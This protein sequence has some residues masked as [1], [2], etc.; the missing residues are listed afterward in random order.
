MRR[1][2]SAIL[3]LLALSLIPASL[4]AR[5]TV[6]HDLKV[7]LY[8]QENRFA[9]K[10]TITVPQK[11]LPD[12]QFRLH[13][14][15]KPLS[16]TAGIRIVQQGSRP[17]TDSLASFRVTLPSGKNTFTLEYGGIINHPLEA[18]GKE[19]ARGFKQTP[20]MISEKGVY[21]A[22]SS[23]WYPVFDEELLT[24][25][26]QV[27]LPAGW[28]AVSQ[29]ERT[30][31]FKQGNVTSVRWESARPQEEIY[32]VAARFTEYVQPAGRIKA[33]VFLRTPDEELALR[34][35]DATARYVVMYEQLIGP[36]PYRKF[37]LVENF[38][39]TGFG[40]PSF[41]LLGPKVI[42]FPFILHSSYPHEI[43][44]NWWGN[45]VFPDYTRGNW[46]EGLTAYLS[47]HLIK[48]QRGQATEYRQAALQKYADYVLSGRDF[49]LVQF[50]SRHSSSSEAVGYGKSLMFFHMLRSQLGDKGFGKALQ[51]FYSKNKFQ[52]ASFEDLRRSFESVAGEDLRKEFSQWLKQPG[53]PELRISSASVRVKGNGFI[54][55]TILEQVQPGSAYYLRIPIAVTMKG[56]DR[57]YQA[58]AIM[59]QKRLE[60]EVPLPARPL[61]LDVDPE[62]DL[63]RRLDRDEIPPALTQAFGAKKMLILLP[64]AAGDALIRAYR[65]LAQSIGRSG[66]DDVTIKLDSEVQ[67]L[68]LDQAVTILGWKNL[69]RGEIFSALSGYDVT[70]NQ[71]NVTIG[72]TSIPR[73]N[74][75]VVLTAR[76]P[77][78]REYSLTWV[79]ADPVDALPGLGRKLPHYH[80]YS[81]LGFEGPEPLNIAK[82]RWPVPASPMTV[83]F[84]LKDGTIAGVEMG[85]LTES[86]PLAS[87]PPVFSKKGMME[88]IRFLSS[89]EL[90]GRGFGSQGLDR[91]AEYI[92]EKFQQAGL[93]PAGDGEG[94]YFQTWE[95][96]GANP[97]R[98]VIMKNVVGVIAG[99]N[100]KLEAQSIVLGAHYD[101][102]GLGW[103]D[104]KENNRGK[105]HYGADDNA[106]GA[107]VL[108]E[109]ARVLGKTLQPDRSVVFVAFTGEEAGKKGSKHYAANQTRYP[110]EQC[111]GMLNLDT[112]GRL[113]KKKLLVLGAGSAAEWKH[114][115]RGAGYV[116]GVEVATVNE[117][118]DASDHISFH[119]AG[120]PAVQLFSGPHPDYHR[121]SDTFDKIDAEGLLKVAAVAKEVIEYLAGREEFMTATLMSGKKAA[122]SPKKSRKA[123]L[124]TIPDFAYSGEGFRISGVVPGS[125]AESGGL[126]AG[127]VIVRIGSTVVHDL[128]GLS[129]IL[130]TLNPGD[131]IAITFLREGKQMTAEAK[132]VER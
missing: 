127:D 33:M 90:A 15:L 18:Y 39:E 5:E 34:Y 70:I 48:E 125:P 82:G 58:V 88:T 66:P 83:F 99:R 68:P 117:E 77:K 92:A 75:C 80:K 130:K 17:G 8:P 56:Q 72:Q 35:L 63:F 104:A 57:A 73:E 98:K 81:Y 111:I 94:S 129:G 37:A 110:M 107:A 121:P 108:I 52:P 21:L 45:G 62:F 50:H 30:L 47:D 43:L 26:L 10:D 46:A 106:S 53:A 128:K 28:M 59:K 95:E 51:H 60:F 69:Y 112:V 49:P 118:L 97:G 14:E 126:K 25:I 109:L 67:K 85:K 4:Q 40:M 29:G 124:G 101:H 11:L 76:H 122:A 131:T 132:V 115:F 2:R 74:H 100:C 27:D 38:W 32:L 3:L 91:A 13:A 64:S 93:K 123:S 42:R 78:N 61:R 55:A 23:F 120:V 119:E 89:S 9:A 102:L 19:Y 84:P 20:G 114:I 41:T 44:H 24:F 7:V 113:G 54:L 31:N 116:T 71:T 22:G 87:L 86:T 16:P 96:R 103:P 6:Q 105:I 65:R 1:L 36:Y 79:A 12:L